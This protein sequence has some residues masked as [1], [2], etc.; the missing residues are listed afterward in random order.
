MRGTL[1]SVAIC[2]AACQESEPRLRGETEL[3][4]DATRSYAEL[5]DEFTKGFFE[6]TPTAAVNSG[7]H[8]YDGRL[9]DYSPEGV[10]AK[11]ASRRAERC[12]SRS[13]PLASSPGI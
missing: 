9:P 2:L 6:L 8:E 1:C 3:S 5:M 11:V 13:R 10:R 7:L 12:A 4:A